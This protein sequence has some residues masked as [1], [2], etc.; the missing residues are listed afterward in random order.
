MSVGDEPS[1]EPTR[2]V[3]RDEASRDETWHETLAFH[4]YRSIAWLGSV[5]PER[6]GRRVFRAAGLLA[7]DL[8]PRTRSIV[9]CNQAR[10]LGRRPG[11]PL[12]RASTRAAFASYARYWYDSFHF[13][14]VTPE[15]VARRFE[16]IG[17]EYLWHSLDAGHGA[18]VALPHV[19][20]WDAA[21]PWLVSEGRPVVAVAE[22]LRPPRLY[23]LFMENRTAL[24]IEVLGL[25]EP[26]LGRK[27]ARR[28]GEGR[29]VALV[30]DRD[31]TGRGV[32]VTMFGRPRRLP[33][34]PALLSITTGAPL[35][36]TPVFQTEDG[37]R[38]VM[39]PPLSV[40][41][42]GDRRADVAAL[43]ERM[44]REFERA[45]ASAPSDWHMFQPAWED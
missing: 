42:T 22:Q 29:I 43:T 27:L 1:R 37:W 28:L 13:I 35:L 15:D 5:L 40:E 41:R 12:V 19:G 39:T 32:E 45:V 6:L 14:A 38:C 20:N 9:A 7:H 21:A 44:A 25:G 31:L 24:G 18:I 3:V 17:D 11:D 10:V 26:G 2:V 30:A 33:A 34:G 23:D 8:M 16:A 4:A 36:V